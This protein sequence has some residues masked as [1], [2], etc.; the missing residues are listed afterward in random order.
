MTLHPF[1]IRPETSAD[2]A[3]IL[4][5]HADRFGPGRFARAAFQVR[6]GVPHDPDL[7]FVALHA[8]RL[9]G[10]VRL[11]AIRVGD[12]AGML[13]GPLAVAPD[14]AG[15]G[16]GRGLMAKCVAAAADSGIRFILL[17]GDQPYYGPF[18]FR[19]VPPGSVVFPAP[20]DPA[21]T[22]V[23]RLG[24]LSGNNPTGP[25]VAAR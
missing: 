1:L 17:V 6:E 4:Q 11:T 3:D 8:G 21:R 25:V 2:N 7:S 18:G 13:L 23:A 5:L 9:I 24:G 19:P 12:E 22:L 16:A 20:V 10:S 14:C 15:R